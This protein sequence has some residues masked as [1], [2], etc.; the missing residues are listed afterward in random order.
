MRFGAIPN[1][2]EWLIVS[3]K[4]YE[5]F[6]GTID[7]EALYQSMDSILKCPKCGRLWVFWDGFDSEPSCYLPEEPE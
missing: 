6:Q 7:A 1:P 3:D 5:S 4:V 2:I